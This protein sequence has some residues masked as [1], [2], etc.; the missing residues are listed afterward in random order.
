MG[1][2][3]VWSFDLMVLRVFPDRIE[4]RRAVVSDY[5]FNPPVQLSTNAT[6]IP[7]YND[8]TNGNPYAQIDLTTQVPATNADGSVNY[9][10]DGF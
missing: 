4:Q 10:I 7:K 3:L 9:R 5:C 2:D 8:G 6:I 1:S